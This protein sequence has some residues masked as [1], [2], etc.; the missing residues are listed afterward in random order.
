[1]SYIYHD[2]RCATKVMKADNRQQQNKRKNKKY[3]RQRGGTH[4]RVTAARSSYKNCN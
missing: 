2:S 1:M 3:K 4:M